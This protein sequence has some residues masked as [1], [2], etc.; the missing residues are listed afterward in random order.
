LVVKK[1]YRVAVGVTSDLD[2]LARAAITD[3]RGCNS[4]RFWL[5]FLGGGVLLPLPVCAS[6]FMVHF[7]TA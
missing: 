3:G 4:R 6:E 5:G 2:D 1:I 7:V